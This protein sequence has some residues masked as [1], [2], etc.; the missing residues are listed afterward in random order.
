MAGKVRLRMVEGAVQL[1]ARRGLHA[2]SFSEVLKLTGSPRGSVYHHFP[3]GKDQL[4]GSAIDLAGARALEYIDRK[5]GAGAVE[6]TEFFLHVWREVLSRSHFQ[7]GCAVLAATIE[8]DSPEL[9]NRAAAIF[10][11][12][13]NRLCELFEQSGLPAREA[14]QFAA[15]LVA[16]SEGAVVL[17][18][19]EQS[20]EPFELVSEQLL[21]QVRKMLEMP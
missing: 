12:W 19:A 2:T 7:A 17:S 8:T 14:A 5:A 11:K 3:D 16:S 21:D 10:R 18:R 15:L 20:M 1:L 6:I 4:I 9:L 13:R